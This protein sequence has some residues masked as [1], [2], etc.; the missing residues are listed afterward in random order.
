MQTFENLSKEGKVAAA[1]KLVILDAIG[2]GK[3]DPKQLAA[4]MD[5]KTFDKA[6]KSYIDLFNNY[7]YLINTK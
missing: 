4:Y 7:G 1:I 2:K 5:S 3:T 6:V